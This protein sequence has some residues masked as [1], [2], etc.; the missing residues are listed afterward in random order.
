MKTITCTPN[1]ASQARIEALEVLKSS[2]LT[3]SD[4]VHAFGAEAANPFVTAAQ[5]KAKDGE[6]EVDSPTV[7]SASDQGAYVMAWV[8]ISNEEAGILTNSEV[9]EEVLDHARLAL[10]NTQN[11][12]EEA[13]IL[14]NTLMGF[15]ADWLEDL[16]A[17]FSDELNDIETE[18]A[19]GLP[20]PVTW[21][22]ED[23]KHV[24]FMAS[25]AISQLRLLARQHGLK[26]ALSDKA[27]QFILKYGNKL[28]AVLTVLQ[29][30]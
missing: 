7:V 3:F 4:C 10:A 24:Q 19:K 1:M 30:A 21:L 22:T 18:V 11:Q 8:W 27:E 6:T 2:G 16:I 13:E 25:D 17:N 23:M 29:T 12:G 28:D 26:D 9:L 5:T 20:G 15:Q 14:R